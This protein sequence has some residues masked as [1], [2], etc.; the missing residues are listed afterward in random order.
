MIKS[1]KTIILFTALFAVGLV[2]VALWSCNHR[3]PVHPTRKT[4]TEAVYASGF[5]SSRNQYKVF[6]LTDGNIMKKFHVAGDTVVMGEPLFLVQSLGPTAKLS[7]NT[8]AYGL[9]VKNSKENSPVLQDLQI[10]INNAQ[11]LLDNDQK[12]YDRTKNMYDANA[13]SRSQLDLAT[14]NLN[15]SKNN[16]QSAKEAYTKTKDQLNVDA[17][18]AEANMATSTQD[19]SNYVLKSLVDGQVYET[20][21]ELGEAVRKNDAVALVGEKGAKYLQLAVDQ[22]DISKIK[23]GQIVEAKMDIA[24]DKIYKARVKKIYPNMN[25]ND[26]SFRVD[27]DF[28]DDP[29][30]QF[31]N[32]SVEAN[33]ILQTKENALVVLRQAIRPGDEVIIKTATGNKNVKITKGL[34]NME[35][36]EVLS[37]LTEQDEIV[38]PKE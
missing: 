24:T 1:K 25:S 30:L 31:I 13:I 21:K 35:S 15:V 34:M 2:S 9:A 10:K 33:I 26:Q 38:M 5:I 7:A 8:S 20:Y 4:I 18:T 27:A 17:K 37:G 32:A 3:K 28:I 19:L 29:G 12:T 14:T 16:L 22:Q 23:I 36:V 6:A 11:V